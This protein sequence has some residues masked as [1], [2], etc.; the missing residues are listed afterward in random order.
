MAIQQVVPISLT[1]VG[2]GNST[3]FKYTISQLFA[4]STNPNFKVISSGTLPSGVSATS[5]LGHV[6]ASMVNGKLVL[7]F[8]TAPAAGL[9][10]EVNVNLF[11]LSQ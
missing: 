7:T 3:I 8:T 4:V 6:Q 2:D 1:L 10:G 5:S 9:Q 11:Y